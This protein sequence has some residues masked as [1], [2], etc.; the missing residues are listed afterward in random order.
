MELTAGQPYWLINSGLLFSYPKLDKDHHAHVAIIGGGIS[1]ALSAYYLTEAGFPCILLD[2]RTIALGST[3]ASTS[4]I[5]Y[6]LDIPLHQL[7]Q[8][9]G[10]I[11]ATRCYQLC[12]ESVGKLLTL[13]RQTGFSDFEKNPSLFISKRTSQKKFMAQELAARKGAGFDVQLLDSTDLK[14]IYGI[15]AFAGI[16]SSNAA[17][18]DTYKLTHH[19]LQ[20]AITKGL[21]VF[22]RTKVSKIK[23]Q[24]NSIELHTTEGNR[25]NAD[26]VI[27]ATGYEVVN[28]ID[29]GF[30]NFDCTYAI[31]SEQQ[32]EKEH[33]WKQG[34]LI[35]TTDDPY[36]YLRTT[37]DN[38]ILA[39]GRDERFSNK[40]TRQVFLDKKQRL[41]EK[42]VQKLMP[43]IS[44]KTEFT[45]SGTF[46]KTKDSLPY[47]GSL[48]NPRILYALGFGGNGITFSLIA[49]EINRDFICGRKNADAAIFNFNRI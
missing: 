1:G 38:R 25:I 36:L 12:Y 2:S 30:V 15:N 47:I 21:K 43:G 18:I 46:G 17:T 13:L 27:N 20:H 24:K 48:H 4:L 6:E 39:G 35:W 8:K 3:C 23:E 10:K 49:A 14:D 28:F 45:W 19:L 26:F 37:A 41:L 32:S 42:D 7:I 11:M 44:F 22:D 31:A 33:L 29:K 40:I 34:T 5:Q 9:K 16:L